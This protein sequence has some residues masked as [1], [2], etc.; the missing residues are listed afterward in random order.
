MGWCWG[1]VGVMFGWW[2]WGSSG[3]STLRLWNQY[4]S[5]DKLGFADPARPA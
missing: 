5:N 4:L 3:G 1:D 2:W